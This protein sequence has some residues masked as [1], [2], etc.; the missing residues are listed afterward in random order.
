MTFYHTWVVKIHKKAYLPTK[1][2]K[3]MTEFENI[4]KI[5]PQT[6]PLFQSSN[7]DIS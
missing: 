2:L 3:I 6:S 1:Q 4:A 5:K 7:P